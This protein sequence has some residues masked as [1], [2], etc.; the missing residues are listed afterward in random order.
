M[1]AEQF[2]RIAS[3]MYLFPGHERQYKERH[4]ALWPE[5]ERSIGDLGVRNYSIF[6][7]GNLL[8]SYFERDTSVAPPNTVD[9]TTVRWWDMMKE[10][11]VSN[12]DSSPV[13]VPI[14][15]VFHID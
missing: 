9:E 3:V 10:H 2:Q 4:D 8:F 11:M 7:Y 15:E 5:M 13:Q 12:A 6:R 1:A 14:E